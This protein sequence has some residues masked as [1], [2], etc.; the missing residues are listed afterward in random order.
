MSKRRVLL[1]WPWSQQQ[2]RT[3]ELFPISLGYLIRSI[4]FERFD[5]RILDC[6]L[7]DIPPEGDA[8]ACELNDFRPD[9]VGVSW[10]SLNTPVVEATLRV[11]RRL[12]PDAL[13][14]A[15]GPHLTGCGRPAVARRA[16][17][18][19]FIGEAELGFARLLE[20]IQD[21]GG[22]P[23]PS[24]LA[25]IP[26]LVYRDAD[27]VQQN[28]SEFVEDL[29][30][31]HGID[32][33]RLRLRDYHARGYYYGAKFQKQSELTAPIMTAR[34]C[35][36]ECTF[37]LAPKID[38]RRIRRHSLEHVINTITMLYHDFGARYIA[39]IDDN[40]T[41]NNKWATK[42]CNAIADLK[43]NDLAI[44]TPNGIPLAGM[45][46]ELAR[47]MKRAGWR[48]VMIAPESGSKR[49]LEA[50]KKPIN[51]DVVP[52]F[53][54]MFHDVGLQVTA[55]FIIGY[56][57]ETLEDI[58]QTKRFIFNNDFDFVGISIYQPLPGSDIYER[59]I[60]E[61]VIP[62]GFIP[63]HYQEVTFRPNNIE[64][65]L[66]CKVYNEIWN[67][68]RELK[69]MPIKNRAVA[70]VRDHMVFSEFT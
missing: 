32:Y 2:G 41:I 53:I 63:G 57:D 34:G 29:D 14:M 3:L 70:C 11:V 10:W 37:C 7:D 19:A 48:E 8:F 36:F 54:R 62:A 15:G 28:P 45:T 16:V 13:V 38:G 25:R 33:E 60:R 27:G 67:E 56:P 17:D 47:A 9:V 22:Y 6:A 30:I 12:R 1:I 43:L 61:N 50:M 59:L 24:V 42:V 51:I 66:L 21:A 4:D 35:P 64:S 52:D 26:G 68:Y 18:F 55:F 20:A 58:A 23:P 5:V 44:G 40:F 69:G 49:T 39:I 31:L 46:I 65:E